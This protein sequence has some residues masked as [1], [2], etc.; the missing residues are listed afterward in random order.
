MNEKE[1]E[2]IENAIRNRELNLTKSYA[3]CMFRNTQPML[4]DCLT[5]LEE[6]G[7]VEDTKIYQGDEEKRAI[8][9]VVEIACEIAEMYGGM[10]Y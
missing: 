5:I 10:E 1:R 8:D 6:C 7:D 9:R 3:Y 4:E 2:S